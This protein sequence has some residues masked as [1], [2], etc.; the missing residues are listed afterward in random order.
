MLI[1]SDNTEGLTLPNFLFTPVFSTMLKRLMRD[2]E[3]YQELSHDVI[4]V[5][6]VPYLNKV[7]GTLIDEALQ[8]R[9][10]DESFGKC[11]RKHVQE[12]IVRTGKK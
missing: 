7:M 2:S 12:V 4:I 11:F 3:V 5:E 6:M 8:G 1:I 10:L 9:T